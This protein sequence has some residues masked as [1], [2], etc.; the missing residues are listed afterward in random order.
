MNPLD[1]HNKENGLHLPKGYLQQFDEDL[2]AELK[3]RE[4][5][6]EHN[7]FVVPQGYF[8][9]FADRLKAKISQPKTKV[10]SIFKSKAWIGSVAAIAAILILAL[11]AIFP[12][13]QISDFD[14][15]TVTTLENYLQEEGILEKMSEEDLDEIEN[16]IHFSEET[17]TNDAILDYVDMNILDEP[18]QEDK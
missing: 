1:N 6:P 13:N 9:K 7:G 8:E 18:K 15:L 17:I 10:I 16:G 14:D 11:I 3:L 2:F 4:L 12:K 5:M